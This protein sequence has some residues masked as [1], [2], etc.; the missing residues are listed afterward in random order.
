MCL[1]GEVANMRYRGFTLVELVAVI[2]FT[3]LIAGITLPV[4]RQ[5]RADAKARQCQ[6]NLRKIV[7]G[8]HLFSTR[9][10]AGRFCT[11][12]PDWSRDGSPDTWGWVADAVNQGLIDS[13]SSVLFCPSSDAKG[14]EFLNQ[15]YQLNP[16][17]KAILAPE[18]RE[19]DGICGQKTFLGTEQHG[20]GS[21]GLMAQTGK[22]SFERSELIARG[23][24]ER[25][26]NTNYTASWFLVRTMP[27]IKMVRDEVFTASEKEGDDLT[28]LTATAGPLKTNVIDRSWVASSR[29]PMFGCGAITARSVTDF[30]YGTKATSTFDFGS[31]PKKKF[32]ARGDGLVAS[33]T[34]GPAYWD[35]KTKTIKS[36]GS[37][38]HSLAKNQKTEA[39][40]MIDP[41]RLDGIVLQDSRAWYAW[42]GD[43]EERFVNIAFGDGSVRRIL[44]RNNDGYLNPGFPVPEGDRKSQRKNGFADSEVEM[45]SVEV[46]SGVFLL[47]LFRK[48]VFGG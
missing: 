44:D 21:I 42:H 40:F 48:A 26:Y 11:G 18:L 45:K 19:L 35:K 39:R 16:D 27:R 30:E 2:G 31:R 32:L 23:F 41:S 3:T 47:E 46:F 20:T 7:I 25:S 15:L 38:G 13:K 33:M 4:L 10:P 22:Q 36:V 6:D 9:D 28:F 12:A 37:P 8:C 29:V 14:S 5:H 24:L 43:S 17:D 34:G 1:E